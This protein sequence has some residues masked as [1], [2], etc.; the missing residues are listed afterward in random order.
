MSGDS[1]AAQARR[2]SAAARRASSSVPRISHAALASRAPRSSP[3]PGRNASGPTMRTAASTAAARRGSGVNHHRRRG[4]A[5]IRGRRL[6][7]QPRGGHFGGGVGQHPVRRIGRLAR[8]TVVAHAG[9]IDRLVERRAADAADRRRPSPGNAAAPGR[10]LVARRAGRRGR[11]ARRRARALRAPQPLDWLPPAPRSSAWRPPGPGPP[12]GRAQRRPSAPRPAP[13][14]WRR[15]L[16]AN[17][18][19]V[20][21]ASRARACAAA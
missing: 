14:R 17:A 20:A 18:A 19:K 15:C 1:S 5:A 10:A 3:L 9:H 21:A 8:G 6:Q 4:Y 11:R 16:A 2:A 12:T 13:G 7:Q